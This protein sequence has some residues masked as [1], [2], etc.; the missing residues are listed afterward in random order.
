MNMIKES[1]F[2]LENIK[3]MY[4]YLLCIK[5]SDDCGCLRG[6]VNR[7][8]VIVK[9]KNTIIN[10]KTEECEKLKTRILELEEIIK[11]N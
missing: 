8:V 10:E 7:F 9:E 11:N 6:R 2:F 4:R 3:E 1:N 5:S